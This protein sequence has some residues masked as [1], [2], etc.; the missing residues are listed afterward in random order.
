MQIPLSQGKVAIVDPENHALFSEHRWSYRAERNHGPG[1]AVRHVK[2]ND[3]DHLSYLHREVMDAPAD[4]LVIFLNHDK[5]DCRKANLKIVSPQEARWYHRARRDSRS[6][7]KGVK[8][9][10]NGKWYASITRFGVFHHLGTF[11]TKGAAL[12][13]YLTAEKQLTPRNSRRRN[14]PK[15]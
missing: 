2:V 8:A 11:A 4:K 15:A 7:I 12:E 10:A 14:Q 5:L 13:A 9:A 3:K 1:C 6:G